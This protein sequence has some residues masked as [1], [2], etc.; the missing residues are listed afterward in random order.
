MATIVIKRE[1]NLD[2]ESAMGRI[3]VFLGTMKSEGISNARKG[4]SYE[5]NGPGIS[6]VVDV[7]DRLIDVAID[8]EMIAKPLKSV[9]EN[10]IQ[11]GLE[12]AF[13]APEPKAAEQADPGPNTQHDAADHQGQSG[14]WI[15]QI[16]RNYEPG[17][18]LDQALYN[19]A[20]VFERDINRLFFNQ[21]LYV[22]HESRIPEHGDYFLFE[23]ANESII[24]S[25][26]K[27]GSVRAN[28]NVCTHRGSRLCLEPSGNVK[29]FVCPYHAWTFALEGD[30][31]A[32]RAMPADFD[33]T[34][35]GLSK[36]HVRVVEGLIYIN[37]A[38]DPIPF[39]AAEKMLSEYIGPHGTAKAKVA[40][41]YR[42][43]VV[44]NWKLVTENFLE[45]Y[46]CAPSHPEYCGVNLHAQGNSLGDEDMLRE[47]QELT[48][49]WRAHVASLGN[50]SEFA[51][52]LQDN[53]QSIVCY[54]QPIRPGFKT[55]SKDGSPLAP[56]MGDF[57]D[58]DG[59]ETIVAMGM[60]NFI[61]AA[62]DHLT[63]FRFTPISPNETEVVLTWLVD[64]NAVE[65]VD[66]NVDDL[67]W[68]WHVTTEQDKKITEDNQAGINSRRYKPGR[69]ALLELP[70][71]RF[72]ARYLKA[73]A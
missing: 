35:A 34:K 28:F 11:D 36:C 61:S 47:Y 13:S 16:V 17:Y 73:I 39:D 43:V 57:A 58:Y 72:V 70:V 42:R 18:T 10:R 65:G 20:N 12:E 48:D 46:H 68:M 63:V 53:E 64:E 71:Q 59:G 56:L 19:D 4:D 30:L 33:K 27:D 14:D 44:A 55:L 6:G 69:Y 66:Y 29:K 21:W 7:S 2:K 62:C 45:C 67:K 60:V 15:S 24:I 1:H 38:E 37:F 54:R 23:I 52:H 26:A 32:A 22:D 41:T 50:M 9:V 49:E 25:R 31:V 51:D 5:I 8:L 40:H 3:G